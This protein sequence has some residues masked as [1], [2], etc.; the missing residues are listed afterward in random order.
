MQTKT[1]TITPEQA[2][3]WLESTNTHNR[4]LYP[5]HVNRLAHDI[6]DGRW[7]PS[8]QGIAFDREG[9][10]LDGQHRLHAIAKSG[11]PVELQ[12]TTGLDPE[13]QEGID[14]G[15]KRTLGHTLA[16][17]GIQ[18]GKRIGAIARTILA[19][20]EGNRNPT[21]VEGADFAHKH[22]ETFRRYAILNDRYTAA[23]AAGFAY[24]ELRGLRGTIFA[25]ERLY[26]LRWTEPQGNDPMRALKQTLDGMRGGTGQKAMATRFWTTYNALRAVDA[27]R[28]LTQAKRLD[29][30]PGN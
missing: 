13:A 19:L 26:D 30:A 12:V 24:G 1:K 3:I 22:L 18:H 10:L 14:Q 29:H 5:A 7:R 15:Y 25:A 11:I 17:E 21:N 27:G 6:E 28:P 20:A 2:T 23:V 9:R 8:H 16:A 4:P